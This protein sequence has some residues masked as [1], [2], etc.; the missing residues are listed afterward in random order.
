MPI[1][2]S[3]HARPR[4]SKSIDVVFGAIAGVAADRAQPSSTSAIGLRTIDPCERDFDKEGNGRQSTDRHEGDGRSLS[5]RTPNLVGDEHADAEPERCPGQGE[6]VFQWSLLG[7][8]S[9]GY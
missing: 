1:E 5:S 3:G 4:D 9:N 7:S 6:Q 8:F 2:S